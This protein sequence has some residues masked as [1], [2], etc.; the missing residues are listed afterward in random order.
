MKGALLTIAATAGSVAAFTVATRDPEDRASVVVFVV[1]LALV[2]GAL[3]ARALLALGGPRSGRGR[4]TARAVAL[5]RGAEVGA[6]V[7]ILATL[8]VIDGLT[9]LTAAFVVLAFA[10]AEYVASARRRSKG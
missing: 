1:A 7:A 9:P 4:T 10:V 8:R 6:C 2:S 5:R 3:T